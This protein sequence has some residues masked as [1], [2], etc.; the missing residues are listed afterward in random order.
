MENKEED[1]QGIFW[2]AKLVVAVLAVPALGAVVALASGGAHKGFLGVVIFVV[3]C[4]VC[5][6]LGMKLMH[7]K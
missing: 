3:A 1:C 4:W 5:T 6:Y 7:R 2:W